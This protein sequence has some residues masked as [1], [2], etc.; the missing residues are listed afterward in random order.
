M[1]QDQ[2]CKIITYLSKITTLV[3]HSRITWFWDEEKNVP[4]FYRDPEYTSSTFPQSVGQHLAEK[5]CGVA[6]ITS[7]IKHITPK[8]IHIYY[9]KGV[10]V[11]HLLQLAESPDD[12]EYFSADAT[13]HIGL[14]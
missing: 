4:A 1:T 3:S 8:N 12:V 7:I 6:E 10:N 11:Q 5:L 9:F 2:R 14:G 13:R